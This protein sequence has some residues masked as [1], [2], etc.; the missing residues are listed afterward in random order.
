M[1]VEE[2]VRQSME[3]IVKNLDKAFNLKNVLKEL[4]NITK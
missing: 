3:E 2:T 1:A 4:T